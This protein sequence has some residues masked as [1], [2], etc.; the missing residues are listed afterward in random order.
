M[1]TQTEYLFKTNNYSFNENIQRSFGILESS[2]V[3]MPVNRTGK[4][5]FLVFRHNKYITVP[6]NTIA[7]FYVKYE[8]SIIVCFDRQEYFVNY[9][10]E[11]IQRLAEDSGFEVKTNFM[12]QRKWF[13][14]AL[15][16]PL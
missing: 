12:D 7:F 9:S 10:L 4:K 1:K 3:P 6:T 14:L 15:L 8:S 16:S 11:Q 2:Y 13:D 5:S